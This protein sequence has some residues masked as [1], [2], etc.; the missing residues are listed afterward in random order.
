ML[1]KIKPAQQLSRLSTVLVS[2]L[3][4]TFRAKT[5]PLFQ[6]PGIVGHGGHF[7]S[8]MRF[9]I[10]CHRQ[11]R[12]SRAQIGFDQISPSAASTWDQSTRLLQH[13]FKGEN[14]SNAYNRRPSLCI[15]SIGSCSYFYKIV[16][17]L[18]YRRGLLKLDH[19]MW[20]LV[21]IVLSHPKIAWLISSGGN[22]YMTLKTRITIPFN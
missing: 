19:I 14:L 5:S 3:H 9:Y 15:W 10:T 8:G 16:V 11:G 20:Q 12:R 2:N 18:L 1:L 21:L 6:I 7:I 13:Y 4:R 17:L 22:K